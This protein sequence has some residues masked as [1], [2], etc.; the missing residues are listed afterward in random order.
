MRIISHRYFFFYFFLAKH[1]H[2]LRGR[3][4]RSFFPKYSN[5]KIWFPI[6]PTPYLPMG[7]M[8][9]P[10]LVEISKVDFKKKLRCYKFTDRQMVNKPNMIKWVTF[11]QGTE[12]NKVFKKYHLNEHL[13]FDKGCM[14]LDIFKIYDDR[15]HLLIIM[16]NIYQFRSRWNEMTSLQAWVH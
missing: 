10:S 8:N 1:K 9:L 12:W 2:V 15:D 16:A 11:L 5:M 6:V 13:F 4:Y 3:F 14:T 7:N